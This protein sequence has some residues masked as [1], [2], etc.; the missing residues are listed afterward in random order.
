M[1]YQFQNN[2]YSVKQKDDPA[3]RIEVVLGDDKQPDFKPQAKIQRWDN[4]VNV[5]IRLDDAD[6]DG[7]TPQIIKDK[8]VAEAGKKEL[9]LYEIQDGFEIEVQLDEKPATNVVRFTLQDK[10]VEYFYQPALTQEEIERGN[11]R[12]DNVV[13][14]YAIYAK[15]PKV[16][17]VGGKEYKTGKVGH[18][19]RPKIIDADKNEIWGELKIENAVLTV[20]IPQGFLD[21]AT[22]PITVDPTFGYSTNGASYSTV[23]ADFLVGNLYTG[24]AGT[25]DSMSLRGRASSGTKNAIIG[26]YKVSDNSLVAETSAVTFTTSVSTQTSNFTASP[27]LSAVDYYLV[28]IVNGDT[29]I[30]YDNASTLYWQSRSYSSGFPATV[31]LGSYADFAYTLYVTYT[32]GGGGGETNTFSFGNFKKQLKTSDL[33]SSELH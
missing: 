8:I 17:Y 2:T 6:F 20:T 13:G 1:D 11:Y 14:S 12:P 15:T 31:S 29:E 18:I 27:T 4:E 3:D 19:Y 28:F 23:G 7:S 25:G 10:D 22:Y 21:T 5:S 33:S 9:R 30:Y 24:A 32:E 26:L 16:N